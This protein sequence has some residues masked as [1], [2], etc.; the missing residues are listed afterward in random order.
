MLSGEKTVGVEVALYYMEN[1]LLNDKVGR[2]E[3]RLFDWWL[4]EGF[5]LVS[6]FKKTD[7]GISGEFILLLG[8][9]I[10]DVTR[11]LDEP[12]GESAAVKDSV[13]KKLNDGW[14]L[15]LKVKPNYYLIMDTENNRRRIE[16]L[17][18]NNIR[19]FDFVEYK[20][21]QEGDITILKSIIINVHR[22][23]VNE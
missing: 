10:Y 18:K 11:T 22:K 1:Y 12:H 9:S 23:K 3:K 14:D 2:L 6:N 7:T 16:E 5:F 4:S 17:F 21:K 19:N 20:T 15:L 13:Q 8:G